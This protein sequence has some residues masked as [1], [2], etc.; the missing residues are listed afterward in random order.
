MDPATLQAR[1]GPAGRRDRRV[2]LKTPTALKSK[3]AEDRREDVRTSIARIAAHYESLRPRYA[4]F[5]RLV[6]QILAERIR[7]RDVKIHSIEARVKSVES[8][9]RKVL[10]ALEAKRSL[11]GVEDLERWVT[12]LAGVR[13]ITFFP[14]TVSAIDTII[15]ERFFVIE[16]D[17]KSDK[18]KVSGRFGYQGVHYLVELPPEEVDR[19]NRKGFGGLVAEI[20]VRTIL[21]HAWAEIEHD[22]QY[23]SPAAMP[24]DIRRRFASLA[25]LLELV[26]R[27][28]QAI[29]DDGKK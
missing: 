15:R 18:L 1:R 14:R 8:V 23:K 20:Q 24:A 27:E 13:V 2:N 22:I 10:R 19:P 3:I 11:R 17:N 16:K 6:R 5:C 12:D 25:G 9:K 4:N 7:E 28:F 26:D 29:R 21:Q